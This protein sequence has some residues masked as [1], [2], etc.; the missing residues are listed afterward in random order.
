MAR[1]LRDHRQDRDVAVVFRW[2]IRALFHRFVLA[3]EDHTQRHNINSQSLSISLMVSK[4]HEVQ[5]FIHVVGTPL[6]KPK[7]IRNRAKILVRLNQPNKNW[8]IIISPSRQR[9]LGY[10]PQRLLLLPGVLP[11][12]QVVL[13][14]PQNRGSFSAIRKLKHRYC[15]TD[16]TVQ[17]QISQQNVPFRYRTL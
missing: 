10:E 12:F 15:D 9:P 3:A 1:S 7:R 6:L 16:T 8:D 4:R 17:L 14:H 11:V 5:G 2:L 13:C